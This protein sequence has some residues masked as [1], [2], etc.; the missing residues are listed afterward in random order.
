[1]IS[2]A[3]MTAP[4]NRTQTV[5]DVYTI[6]QQEIYPPITDGIYDEQRTRERHTL[7]AKGNGRMKRNTWMI[8]A[9]VVLGLVLITAGGAAAVYA[10]TPKPPTPPDGQHGPGW[11][12]GDDAGMR[13]MGQAELDA[14]AKALGMTADDL[15]AELKAGKTLAAV[16]AEKGVTLQVVQDAIKAAHSTEFT[17]HIK[18]AVTHGNMSQ[19]KADWLLEGLA[20][21]YLDG[22]D[23]FGLGHGVGMGRPGMSPG[24]Q[25]PQATPSTNP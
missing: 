14:A 12:G 2:F 5:H 9:G 18:Q 15:S 24:G 1:M 13:P 11:R 19:A 3:L 8:V 7:K 20:K 6:P 10:Q 25:A 4:L 21:G 23:G 22:P 16:A 17:A